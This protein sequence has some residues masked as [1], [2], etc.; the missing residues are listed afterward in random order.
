M[1]SSTTFETAG[2]HCVPRSSFWEELWLAL[3]S[4]R[5]QRRVPGLRLRETLPLGEKR[6]L[7]VVEFE[8][9]RFLLAATSENISLLQTLGPSSPERTARPEGT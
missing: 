3:K 6:M 5:V 9:Q 1:K 4:I 8:E 7:A 2:V